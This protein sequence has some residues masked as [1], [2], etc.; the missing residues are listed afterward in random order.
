MLNSLSSPENV[1]IW[2]TSDVTA[3][4]FLFFWICIHVYVSWGLHYKQQLAIA[5]HT[6]KMIWSFLFYKTGLEIIALKTP[7]CTNTRWERCKDCLNVM[8]RPGSYTAPLWTVQDSNACLVVAVAI[9]CNFSFWKCYVCLN[10]D[11]CPVIG[12]E[13][14]GVKYLR[15]RYQ[16]QTNSDH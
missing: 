16:V 13:L 7:V 1:S 9:K 5:S 2:G 12:C 10:F 15:M 11:T 14:L 8:A 3:E 4:A 6:I